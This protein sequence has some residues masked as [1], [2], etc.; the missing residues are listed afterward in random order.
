[1]RENNVQ[2]MWADD[3][4]VVNGWLAIANSFSAE[5]MS[6]EAFDSVTVD[7]QHGMVDFQ[8]AVAM[9]QAISTRECTPLA[10]V[11]WNDPALIMKSLDAGSY[12]IVCP[13]INNREEC[14]KFVGACRYAPAG[15]R[16]FGP[17][18][19]LLYGGGDYA[20]HANDTV[21]TLAMIETAEAMDNL[22]EIMS[23]DG[24]DAIYVG[25]NDLA[26][27]LGNPPN[28]EPTAP[29]VI[30]AVDEILAA[31]KR[32]NVK[33]GIHCPSGA[34]ALDK[35]NKGFRFATIAND[36]RLLAQAAKSEIATARGKN[37][38]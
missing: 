6:H 38:A 25:P 28:P 24:L 35:F 19:G 20:A 31:A 13:M 12:G 30:E 3:M 33:A 18:R 36:A 37:T 15:Y 2:K 34:S 1:M 11:P 26:I 29:N 23:V 21:V 22:D 4:P 8:A 16:S 7:M 5:V 9:F 27:S 10:R 32:N 17:A 14:E